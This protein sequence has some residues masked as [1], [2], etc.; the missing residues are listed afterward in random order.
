VFSGPSAASTQLKDSPLGRFRGSCRW[1]FI[2]LGRVQY[3]LSRQG[4][5]AIVSARVW[6]SRIVTTLTFI[7]VSFAQP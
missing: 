2:Q 6:V 7:L 3:L 4:D 1:Y 5:V